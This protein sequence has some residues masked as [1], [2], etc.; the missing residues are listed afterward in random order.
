MSF[1]QWQEEGS[2]DMHQHCPQQFLTCPSNQAS[3]TYIRNSLSFQS[4]KGG[5]QEE[6]C[7]GAGAGGEGKVYLV[8][9]GALHGFDGDG[10]LVDPQHTTALTRGRAHPACELWEVVGLQQ[11]VQGLLPSPLVY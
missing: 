7:P 11:A 9:D 3:V 10:G 6:E 5:L 2:G 1:V 4:L 8:D